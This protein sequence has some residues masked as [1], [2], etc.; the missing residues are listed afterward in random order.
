MDIIL[1]IIAIVTLAELVSWLAGLIKWR[2]EVLPPPNINDILNLNYK[3]EEC[4]EKMKNECIN[5]LE[6]YFKEPA[7]IPLYQRIQTKMKGLNTEQRKE[8]LKELSIKA[9]EVMHIKLDNIEF[10]NDACMGAYNS[11]EN[12]LMISNAYIEQD[13]CAVE[14]VK[15]I[16]HELKHVVQFNAIGQG[17]NIWGYSDDTLIAWVNNWQDYISPEW[18]PEGYYTQ[19]MEVDSFGFECSVIPQPG[20]AAP[21]AH[22]VNSKII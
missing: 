19:P 1:T 12:S 16:F 13:A 3:P 14:V 18:D 5:L 8:L 17:G 20:L 7:D 10:A 9:S 11:Q 4:D 15:T 6:E 2:Q 22:I 21:N